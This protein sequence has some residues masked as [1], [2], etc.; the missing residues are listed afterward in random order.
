M[1]PGTNDH[2]PD[3]HVTDP[4]ALSLRTMMSWHRADDQRVKQA[5]AAAL[6]VRSLLENG[7][8]RDPQ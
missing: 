1:Q 7:I 2:D 3:H 4:T 5:F 6:G 8:Q